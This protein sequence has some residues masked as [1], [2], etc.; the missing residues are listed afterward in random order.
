MD[1]PELIG[2][3]VTFLLSI[4]VVWTGVQIA[5][6]KVKGVTNVIKET[7]EAVTVTLKH[8]EDGKLTADEVKVSIKEFKDIIEAAKNAFK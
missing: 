3:G 2:M 5:L 7:L 4:G 8:L 1:I 6:G